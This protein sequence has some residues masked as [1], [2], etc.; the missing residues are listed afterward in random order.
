M[1]YSV[2]DIFLLNDKLE[3]NRS[4]HMPHLSS[5]ESDVNIRRGKAWI[6]IDRL[7]T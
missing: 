7:M 6:A 5:S 3:I 1:G 4:V 2:S